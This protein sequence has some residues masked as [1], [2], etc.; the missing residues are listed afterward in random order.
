MAATHPNWIARIAAVVVLAA[1]GVGLWY[2]GMLYAHRHMKMD[3]PGME[4]KHE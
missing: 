3:M 4:H 2:G 1:L